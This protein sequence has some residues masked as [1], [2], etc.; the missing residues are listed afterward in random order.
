M[1]LKSNISL[2]LTTAVLAAVLLALQQRAS[3]QDDFGWMDWSDGPP[4]WRVRGE[5]LYWWTNGNPLPPLVTTS[6]PGTPITDAGVLGT[7][8]VQTLFGGRSIDNGARSGGRITMSRWLDEANDT[9]FE[10]VG[11]YVADDYQSG[12]FV[13]QSSG[14]PILSRPF[15]D[16]ATGQENAELVAFPGRL[17]GRV[18][19][20]SYS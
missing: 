5:Y 13:A 8:G 12:N 9:A 1:Q 6:P 15:I 10:F 14:S 20:N 2:F 3:A 4:I 16:A 19:V 11:F 7:N 17:A 18:T